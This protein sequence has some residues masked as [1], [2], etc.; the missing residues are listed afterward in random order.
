MEQINCLIIYH[1]P[2]ADGVASAFALTE[3]LRK[4]NQSI[5]ID[6]FPTT[7]N[8]KFPGESLYIDKN[9]YLVDFS[10]SEE[11]IKLIAS[12]AI[13]VTIY[14]HHDTAYKQLSDLK[15]DNLVMT[16]DLTQSACELIWNKY[17]QQKNWIIDYIGD[18]DTW[19]F[20]L[21]NSK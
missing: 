10:F 17:F 13:N 6:Y 5:K 3:G 20:A 12:K 19:K 11:Q 16:F 14:D 2:C 1:F 21:P 18:R 7:H 4:L 8:G 9:V 15:L